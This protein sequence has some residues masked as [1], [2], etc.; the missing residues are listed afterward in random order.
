MHQVIFSMFLEGLTRKI[1]TEATSGAWLRLKPY[2]KMSTEPHHV[3]PISKEEYADILWQSIQSGMLDTKVDYDR[4][5]REEAHKADY[6][7][8]Y[9]VLVSVIR[10][11]VTG[12]LVEIDPYFVS[13]CIQELW[14]EQPYKMFG[15]EDYVTFLSRAKNGLLPGMKRTDPNDLLRLVDPKRQNVWP[16]PDP[17]MTRREFYDRWH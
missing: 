14:S 9:Y 3:S 13:K 4:Q 11:T 1:L 6:G 7:N 8:C 2:D 10:K 17:M 15:F 5:R 12:E 16:A